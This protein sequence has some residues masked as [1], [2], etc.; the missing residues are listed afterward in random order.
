MN[1]AGQTITDIFYGAPDG[2]TDV[3]FTKNLVLVD[4][5][6]SAIVVTVT[7]VAGQPG[8]Y[9]L[10]FTPS[11]GGAYSLLITVG[12]QQWNFVYGVNAATVAAPVGQSD[13]IQDV[14]DRGFSPAMFG[15]SPADN[16][17]FQTKV[18]NIV[19]NKLLELRAR[20][21]DD[22]IINATDE[23]Q[24]AAANKA[25]VEL[26]VAQLWQMRKARLLR[27]FQGTAEAHVRVGL[28]EEQ[29]AKDALAE[30]DKACEWIEGIAG[31][32]ST[33]ASITARSS[34][35][36]RQS[37]LPEDLPYGPGAPPLPGPDPGDM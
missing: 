24:I 10:S 4:G 35:F 17:G 32:P 34:H 7:P 22:I 36:P 2:L 1:I 20:Y 27:E 6:A 19:A 14:I 12:Q 29:A 33:F 18:A 37:F 8:V 21:G 31:R 3:D 30:Y 26:S 16:A 28:S 11:T 15:L 23:L 9:S 25:I 5:D 13:L